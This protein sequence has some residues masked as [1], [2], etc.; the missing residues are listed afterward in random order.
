M[1][2]PNGIEDGQVT[3]RWQ[4]LGGLL[5]ITSL[6]LLLVCVGALAYFLTLPPPEPSCD[7]YWNYQA[8]IV[9]GPVPEGYRFVVTSTSDRTPFQCYKLHVLQNGSAWPDWSGLPTSVSEGVLTSWLMEESL[10][11]SDSDGDGRLSRGDYF[12]M[13]DL[14]A[15]TEYELVLL[16]PKNS[17]MVARA[18]IHTP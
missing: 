3:G 12:E 15:D 18:T 4:K 2:Q 14:Q 16:N 1:M 11:F 10:S 6:A 9:A 5:I 13:R 17:N 8:S 7:W